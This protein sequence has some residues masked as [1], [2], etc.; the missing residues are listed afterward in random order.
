MAICFTLTVDPPA[1]RTIL[2]PTSILTPS[3]KCA[4]KNKSIKKIYKEL[5]C[6]IKN[7]VK[8]FREM[9]WLGY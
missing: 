4:L 9:W 1:Y 2:D 8:Q 5:I 7:A 3:Q 6:T